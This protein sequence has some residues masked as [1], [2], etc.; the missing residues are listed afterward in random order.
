MNMCYLCERH[1]FLPPNLMNSRNLKKTY[2]KSYEKF[3]LQNSLVLSAPFVMNRSGDLLNNYSGLSIKQKIPLR[4]YIW[5]T[6]NSSGKIMLWTMSHF[7]FD[8]FNYID[9]PLREYAPYFND[10]DAYIQKEYKYL[11]EKHEGIEINMLS[12]L[13]RWVGLWFGSILW[14]LFSLLFN[15]LGNWDI[16]GQILSMTTMNIRRNQKISLINIS[17][18][19]FKIYFLR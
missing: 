4:M 11:L 7:D 10:I 1:L 6:K 19:D 5:C 16:S 15:C 12:E 14:L 13:P 9:T 2:V 17:D 3:F 8:E 18:L